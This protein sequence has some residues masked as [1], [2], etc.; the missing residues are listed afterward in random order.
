MSLENKIDLIDAA[1]MVADFW[2]VEPADLVALV[3]MS[4]KDKVEEWNKIAKE[5]V[6]FKKAPFKKRAKM[7]GV[8]IH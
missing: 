8:R 2:G 1:I 7:L 3:A 5:V 4:K 6:A